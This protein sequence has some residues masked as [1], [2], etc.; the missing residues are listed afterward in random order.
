MSLPAEYFDR[1]YAEDSD[2]WGF[3]TRWYERRKYDLTLA[4]L[5]RERYRSCFEPGCSI[6][7]LTEGLA[8]RCD[9]VLAV[10][11][12]E[13]A[14]AVA[15][16]RL[17]PHP[18]VRVRRERVPQW[19]PPE[20]FDL[21]VVSEIGYYLDVTTLEALFDAAAGSLEQAG[22]LVAVHWRLHA[23]DYPLRGDAVHDRLRDHAAFAPVAAYEEEAFRIDVVRRR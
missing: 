13:K 2:P 23:A 11:G 18:G 8:A 19:W 6:G 21:V 1:I 9:R 7:V 22:D 20:R 15:R 3:A 16:A 5:P 14:L 10:D 4:A 17:A 12:A